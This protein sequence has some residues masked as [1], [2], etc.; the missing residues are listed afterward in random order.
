MHVDRE[1]GALEAE[2]E[3][4]CHRLRADSLEATQLSLYCLVIQFPDGLVIG[5]VGSRVLLGVH[6]TLC[7]WLYLWFIM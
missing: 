7:P 3:D 2:H 6:V 4:A 5:H 1:L